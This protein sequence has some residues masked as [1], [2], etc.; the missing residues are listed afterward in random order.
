M[1][2]LSIT[3]R[4]KSRLRKLCERVASHRWAVPALAAIS[5]LGGS[6][7]PLPSDIMLV[8][9]VVAQPQRWKFFTAVTITSSVA[10][11][12]FAYA[13]GLFLLADL[14]VLL[15]T[16]LIA[17]LERANA[18]LSVWGSLTLFTAALLPIPFKVLAVSYG[19]AKLS[20]PAFLMAVTLG[21]SL[22]FI[23]M[24]IAILKLQ[25]KAET[26]VVDT[27]KH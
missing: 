15:N 22:R 18:T 12:L 11:A 1:G 24:S 3:T 16:E 26:L 8:P 19:A 4:A 21:R 17:E 13:I 23:L 10:G 25:A 6:I 2:M 20:L 14:L 5:F 7:A 9:M 27:G